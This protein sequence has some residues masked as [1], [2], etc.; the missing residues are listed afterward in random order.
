MTAEVMTAE[1]PTV[2]YLIEFPKTIKL[3]P[4]IKG[5]FHKKVITPYEIHSMICREWF[6]NNA[7]KVD[8][9]TVSLETART[10]K[11]LK[12]EQKDR[13]IK[14]AADYNEQE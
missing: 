8:F 9:A 7:P 14:A 12:K 3:I 11:H 4:K 6:Q 13:Y 2:P 5:F 10:W 1:V